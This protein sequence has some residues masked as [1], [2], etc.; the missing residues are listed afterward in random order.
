MVDDNDSVP[1]RRDGVR[2]AE[3][4]F[5]MNMSNMLGSIFPKKKKKRRTTVA[6]ARK[7][8]TGGGK[9]SA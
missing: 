2:A 9:P 5:T 7:I 1:I 8:F 3:K 4:K 6:A